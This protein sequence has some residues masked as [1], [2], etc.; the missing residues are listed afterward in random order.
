MGTA[1]VSKQSAQQVRDVIDASH[2]DA[3]VIELCGERADKLRARMGGRA[4][5]DSKK[6][7][8]EALGKLVKGFLPGGGGNLFEAI[9]RMFYKIFQRQGADPGGEFRAAMEECDKR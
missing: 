4:G 1:H 9:L 3:V 5:E 7:D 6:D 2:P 8:L